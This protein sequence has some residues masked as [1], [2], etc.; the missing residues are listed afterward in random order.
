VTSRRENRYRIPRALVGFS[1]ALLVTGDQK[2]VDAWRDMI[3]AVN[4]N[5]RVVG[6]RREYPTDVRCRRMVRVATKGSRARF[7]FRVRPLYSERLIPKQ[8]AVD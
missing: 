5:A 2:Y 1:N 3:A 4:S 7:A 8:R 6:G